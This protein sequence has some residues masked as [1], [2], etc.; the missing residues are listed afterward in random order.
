MK[1]PY[2]KEI[3][4][5]PSSAASWFF[6]NP[7]KMVLLIAEQ[8]GTDH[9]THARLCFCFCF[10]F[11]NWRKIA[12]QYFVDFCHTAAKP[13]ISI[14]ISPPTLHFFP[15]LAPECQAELF[16]LHSI[17]S[18]ASHLT[19]GSEHVSAR[20]SPFTPLSPS[21]TVST[22]PFPNLHLYP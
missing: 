3:K 8:K 9:W 14:H 19:C 13:A 17:L 4:G 7:C 16:V 21:L 12:L 20:L 1:G 11:F 15:P 6:Y 2:P 10:K 18:P 5:P 22:S